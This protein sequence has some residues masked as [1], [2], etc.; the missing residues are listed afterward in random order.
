MLLC[1]PPWR[2]VT[3]VQTLTYVGVQLCVNLEKHCG[4]YNPVIQGQASSLANRYK[5]RGGVHA[6]RLFPVVD[7]RPAWLWLWRTRKALA[8]IFL[9]GYR[10]QRSHTIAVCRSVAV[11][12]ST[13]GVAK[14]QPGCCTAAFSTITSRLVPCATTSEFGLA[15]LVSF[16]VCQVLLPF[17]RHWRGRRNGASVRSS[18]FSFLVMFCYSLSAFLVEDLDTALEKSRDASCVHFVS[19]LAFKGG[20]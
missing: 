18:F 13:C 16:Y 9:R 10:C 12:R 8:K 14:Q 6:G 2:S 5:I 17:Y 7:Q 4:Q 15:A 3:I 19:A 20:S 11:R 1:T